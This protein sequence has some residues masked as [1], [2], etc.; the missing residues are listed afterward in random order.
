MPDYNF[1]FVK[2]LIS[3]AMDRHDKEKEMTALLLSSLYVDLIEP[4]QVYKGFTKL[5]ESADDL[6]VDIPDTVEV[7]ALF[8]ARAVVDD[9]LPP[10]FLAKATSS[11][12]PENCKGIEAINRA[13]KSY[14]SAPL[15]AEVIERRWGGSTKRT[16]DDL[17]GKINILLKEYVVSGDKKE[18]FRCIK[19]LNVPYFHHEIVKRAVIL[20]MERV[21]AE[22]RVLELLKTASEEGLINSSQITKGFTRIIDS[23]D[24]LSLDVPNAKSILQMLISK[25]ASEGWLSASSL[26]SISSVHPPHFGKQNVAAESSTVKRFKT[27]AESII[28][29]Y[30]LTGDILEVSRCL[31]SEINNSSCFQYSSELNAIFIKKLVS[32]AMDRKNRE[33]EMASVLLSSLCFSTEDT[34]SGFTMLIEAA[35]DT[36]IDIPGAVEDLAMFLARAVVDE[37]LAPQHLEELGGGTQNNN[38]HKVVG[39]AKSLLKARLSGERILR[40][41]GGGGNGTNGWTTEEVKEK[42][43]KLLEE[44]ECGGDSRE[45]C[46]CIKELGMPFFHHEVVKKGVVKMMEKRSGGG[47]GERVWG[48]LR[49]CFGTGL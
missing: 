43:A 26:K 34:V 6:I 37:A 13:K 20:S 7:L 15:H 18:A 23:I 33:K 27:K 9:I 49:E 3:M 47:G 30:F 1:Y 28:K 25:A 35:E 41:W 39:M 29:E 21:A 48:L 5:L 38:N 31:E 10:A 8:I 11:L 44:F 36:A 4:Q 32:L 12:P 45:A 46:R 2:K 16:V 14:L 40:C 17:K 19:D 42:I 24:D 22:S